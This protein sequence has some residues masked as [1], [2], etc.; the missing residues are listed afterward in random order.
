MRLSNRCFAV[1]GLCYVP[2]W[3]VNAGFVTGDETTL[4]IDTGA[5]AAAAAT[6]HGYATTARPSNPLLVLDTERHFDHIG[7]NG[8]FRARGIDI[9][10]HASIQRTEDE[11]R[12]EMAEFNREVSSPARR[13]NQDSQV[14]YHGTRLANPNHPIAGDCAMDLGGCKIEVLLTPGHTPSNISVY[15]PSDGALYCGDCLVNG[16]LPNLDGGS[17]D[18]WRAWLDSLER[19]A[20]L[21]PHIV[22]AGHGPVATGEEVPSMIEKLREIL[23]QSIE[24]GRSPTS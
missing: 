21:A 20:A 6:I 3:S 14:F 12:L 1:T 5:N 19:V 4:I 10:G 17:I 16:Y 15:V 2:P 13:L 11:F 8:Y 9:Y 7:G 24:T 22:V 23:R 18:D